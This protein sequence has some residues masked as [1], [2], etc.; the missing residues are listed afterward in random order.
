MCAGGVAVE[1]PF[2]LVDEGLGARAD[3]SQPAIVRGYVSALDPAVV[4]AAVARAARELGH[5]QAFGLRPIGELHTRVVHEEDWAEAWKQHF[6]VLHVGRR[7]VVVP[8]WRE[9]EPAAGEVVIALDPGMAFGT[10][11]HPT[12]GLCLAGIE[13]WADAGLLDGASMLDVGCGSGILGICAALLGA[14]EVL[15]VDTDPV[16]VQTTLDNAARNGIEGRLTACRGS[17][18]LAESGQYD[19]VVANLV[20]GILVDLAE[21]LVAVVRADGRLLLGGIFVDRDEE[22]ARAFESA[23]ARVVGR[24]RERDWVTLDLARDDR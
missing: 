20:A 14:A 17:L 18:P 8:T 21:E 12:T 5:L 9:H 3:P 24:R 15:A 11:L 16:A 10:G 7:I 22:V 6:P 1:T 19:L 23:G 13:A 2:E 4:G